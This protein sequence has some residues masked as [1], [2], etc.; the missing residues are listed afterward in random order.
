[1]SNNINLK[2]II[3]LIKD[4][5]DEYELRFYD[6][7]FNE[8]TKTF[9]L[10][11][12]RADGAVNIEDCKMVSRAVS[13]ELDHSDLINFTYGLEVSSPGVERPLTKPDHF[14]WAQGKMVEID[15]KER[16][17]KGYLRYAKKQGI[18]VATDSGESIVPYS[19]VVKA[20]VVEDLDYGKRR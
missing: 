6:L 10:F 9:R 5:L 15:T 2:G 18:V 17:I 12:D 16:K 11:I 13:R 14:I 3:D 20:K 8:V 7:H 4:I 19:S 1:M